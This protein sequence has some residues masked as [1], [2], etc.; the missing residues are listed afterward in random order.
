MSVAFL[1]GMDDQSGAS[2]SNRFVKDSRGGE[3]RQKAHEYLDRVFDSCR[4]DDDREAWTY[5]ELKRKFPLAGSA[6]NAD[7]SSGGAGS[8][9]GRS[10]RS[11]GA[12]RR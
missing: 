6:G 10:S 7:E 8:R 1:L 2:K 9:R 12:G 3:T 4:G 11:R 5:I